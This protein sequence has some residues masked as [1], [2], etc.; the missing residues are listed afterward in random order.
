ML[1]LGISRLGS[2]FICRRYVSFAGDDSEVVR[3]GLIASLSE[4]V[5]GRFFSLTSMDSTM[6]ARSQRKERD[7]DPGR[8]LRKQQKH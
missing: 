6:N 1:W 8:P 2:D 3:H 7:L 4:F 5:G